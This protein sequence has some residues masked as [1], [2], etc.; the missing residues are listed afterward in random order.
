[1]TTSSRPNGLHSCTGPVYGYRSSVVLVQ[2]GGC[3]IGAFSSGAPWLNST[4]ALGVVEDHSRRADG[5]RRARHQVAR[6]QGT[7][8][9][10]VAPFVARFEQMVVIKGVERLFEEQIGLGD[11]SHEATDLVDHRQR[12]DP[13]FR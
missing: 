2:A 3:D 4:N 7:R 1:M 10:A 12:A 13:V 8:L 9:G 6:E 11:H 5:Q